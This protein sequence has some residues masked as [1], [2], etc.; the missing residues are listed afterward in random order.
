MAVGNENRLRDD[1]IE[2][3]FGIESDNSLML[4]EAPAL[5]VTLNE[6]ALGELSID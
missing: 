4:P 1:L 6:A 2:R 3:R 5:G